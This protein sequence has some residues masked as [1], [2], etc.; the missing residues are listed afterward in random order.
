MKTAYSIKSLFTPLAL[1]FLLAFSVSCSDKDD[2]DAVAC[3]PCTEPGLTVPDSL[4]GEFTMSFNHTSDGQ[5]ITIALDN[6]VQP[7]KNAL[8]QPYNVT[9]LK[10]YVSNVKLVNSQNGKS[11]TEPNS[12]HLIDLKAGK[13]SFTFTGIPVKTYDKVEFSIGVDS[14]QNTHIDQKGDLNPNGDMA[15]TWNTGYIFFKLDGFTSNN[16]GLGLHIGGTSNYK[17]LSF[18][19][20]QNVT[21][22]KGKPVTAN[23]SVKLEEFF[24]NPNVIN[25]DSIYHIM[26]GPYA[27]LFAENYADGMF[28]VVSISQ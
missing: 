17:K 11:F 23:V 20:N 3:N 6:T 21:F 1:A 4:A 10:Y 15:W 13:T 16:K 5:A 19:L 9:N 12:Y 26:G 28:N 8:N 2:D 7:Y 27:K 14:V 25:F 18:P 22:Q 24:H